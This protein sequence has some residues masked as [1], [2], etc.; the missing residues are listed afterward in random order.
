MKAVDWINRLKPDQ[1]RHFVIT[2]LLAVV[3]AHLPVGELA[4]VVSEPWMRAM[5]AAVAVSLMELVQRATGTG[6]ADWNDVAANTLGAAAV[7]VAT[8]A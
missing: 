5:W 8:L 3:F 4:Y 1:A 7:A 6:V 2:V